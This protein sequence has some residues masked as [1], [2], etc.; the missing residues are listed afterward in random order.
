YV[1]IVRSFAFFFRAYVDHL[2]LHSFPIRRSSDLEGAELEDLIH[3][4]TMSLHMIKAEK[5]TKLAQEY[6]D[7]TSG[8]QTNREVLHAKKQEVLEEFENVITALKGVK[9]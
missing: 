3:K 6:R 4:N 9:S 1:G 7:L 5:L 2:E 8:T